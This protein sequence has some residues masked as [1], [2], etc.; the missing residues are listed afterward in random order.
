MQYALHPIELQ[1]SKSK[2]LNEFR[3][4][5]HKCSF[6]LRL[7][8]KAQYIACIDHFTQTPNRPPILDIDKA[9]IDT[10]YEFRENIDRWQKLNLIFVRL[11]PLNFIE[12]VWK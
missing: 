5:N 9:S 4:V 1:S 12:I 10:S 2:P 11:A 3:F 6:L 8:L 7:S